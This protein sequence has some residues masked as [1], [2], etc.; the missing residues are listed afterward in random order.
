MIE[1]ISQIYRNVD[2]LAADLDR[3]FLEFRS[4]AEGN[5]DFFASVP[6]PRFLSFSEFVEEA[7]L[8]LQSA[9]LTLRLEDFMIDPLKEFRKI[10][11]LMSVNLDLSGLQIAPPKTKP[12]GYLAVKDRVPLFRDYLNGLDQETK[13]R[14]EKMGYNVAV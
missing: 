12:Y 6:G 11:E 7:E 13:R 14:I 5:P 3:N 10:V 8:F 1:G 2:D 4:F 9:T